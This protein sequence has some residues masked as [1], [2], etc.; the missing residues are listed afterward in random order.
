[1]RSATRPAGHTVEARGRARHARAAGH[2][3]KPPE[4][5]DGHGWLPSVAR[6][7]A[8]VHA[9]RCAADARPQTLTRQA[10]RARRAARIAGGGGGGRSVARHATP[11]ARASCPVPASLSSQPAPPQSPS[12]AGRSQQGGQPSGGGACGG[13]REVGEHVQHGHRAEQLARVGRDGQPLEAVR[14]EGAQHRVQRVGRAHGGQAVEQRRAERRADGRAQVCVGHGARERQHALGRDKVDE[15]PRLGHD[16]QRAHGVVRHQLQR[17]PHRRVRQRRAADGVALHTAVRGRAP[18]RAAL[19]QARRHGRRAYHRARGRGA[20]QQRAQ[21]ERAQRLAEHAR[22]GAEEGRVH[23]RVQHTQW[24]EH[25]QDGG[26]LGAFRV[27]EGKVAHPVLQHVLQ[28]GEERVVR[29]QAA[30]RAHR[31]GRAHRAEHLAQRELVE[32]ALRLRARVA[33]RSGLRGVAPKAREQAGDVV[34]HEHREELLPARVPQRRVCEPV[35]RKRVERVPQGEV[36]V[37]DDDLAALRDELVRLVPVQLLEHELA[38]ALLWRAHQ[39]SSQFVLAC[40][41]HDG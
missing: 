7:A 40:A 32:R 25:V 8:R 30:E 31:V 4:S 5:P 11:A 18:L 39:R 38:R 24:R 17:V 12:P 9:E 36:D 35:L 34:A 16:G 22:V 28:R 26:R 37:E 21:V 1:M 29:H 20:R 27:D 19:A 33:R 41:A 3:R 6:H 10:P 14:G 2:A 13:R 15:L 23:D